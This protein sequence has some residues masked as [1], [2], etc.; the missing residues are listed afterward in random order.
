MQPVETWNPVWANIKPYASMVQQIRATPRWTDRLR[1]LYKKPGWRPDDQ[2]G[3]QP[4][5]EVDKQKYQKYDA[6]GEAS[7][8]YYVFF[9]FLVA[10]L[11]TGFFLFNARSMAITEKLSAADL[12]LFS[13]I[14][15][16]SLFENARKSIPLEVIRLTFTVMLVMYLGEQLLWVGTFL[17]A[18]IAYL[19]V[20]VLWLFSGSSRK[21]AK[22]AELANA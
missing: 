10:L 7:F 17:G 9:Q 3:Y 13:L 6:K 14:S 20:S 11:S 2:G 8:H 18:A 16:G 12:I 21:K 19:L 15:L 5:P 1:V 22:P 4:P